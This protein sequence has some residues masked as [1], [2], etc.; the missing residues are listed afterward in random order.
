MPIV[1]FDTDVEETVYSSLDFLFLDLVVR[2]GAVEF[3]SGLSFICPCV[4]T[5]LFSNSI[6]KFICF[7]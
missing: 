4:R 6:A 2:C 7:P 1:G 3:I 5:L